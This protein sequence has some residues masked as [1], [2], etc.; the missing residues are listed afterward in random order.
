MAT[1]Y[2]FI[3]DLHMGGDEQL[4][5]LDFEV[6]LLDFLADLEERGG[7][8]ELII[9][10]DAFGL[11]E[12]A[13]V[14]GPAK[15]ERVIAD[16][17]RVFEQLRATGAEIDITLI[18]GNHDYDLACYPAHVDRLAEFNV[19]LEPEIAITREVGDGE[20]WIEHGQ[21]H[22]A[23]NRLPDWGNPD[24][25]P[26]GYFVVQRI[27]DT[28]GRYSGRASGDWLRDIQSVAPME[29]I[30]RWLLSNYFY[31]EMSPYLRAIIVPLLLFFNIT[32]VYL[33]G[34]VLEVAGILP[35]RL[36]TDNLVVHALGIADIVLEIIVTINLVIIAVLLLLAVPLWF[37]RHDLRHTL[38]RFGVA[39]SG[40][41]VG[42]GDEPFL[43][44]AQETL[45]ANRDVCVYV[46]GHTHRASLAKWGDRVVVNTGTWLKKLQ[47]VETRFSR[48]PGVYVPSFQ[49]NYVRIF[50]EGDRIVVEYEEIDTDKP[51][52]LTRFQ[53]LIARRPPPKEP[54]P[55]RTVIDPDGPLEVPDADT[56]LDSKRERPS[57]PDGGD[58][59]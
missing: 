50:A 27:V 23:N 56:D 37:F 48:L 34:T 29:E 14:T 19:A 9:N 11:W 53:R 15:L 41:R 21:Q 26:V 24:A 46:Y 33:F 7:D 28:A 51:R 8:V 55:A 52:D 35:A 3:S 49:L 16:H 45:E 47:H 1:E 38:E 59:E 39:L 13:E 42:Q 58:G 25:L 22:D 54:I 20:I 12:Y 44:A 4:T 2:V 40:I 43:N 6:E 5:T 10:G 36:F 18:P 57:V 31:R 17:P 32:L 30:P